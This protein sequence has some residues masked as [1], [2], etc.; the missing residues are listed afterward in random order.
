MPFI[1]V[2]YSTPLERD[3]RQEIAAFLT[4]S[5]GRVLRKNPEITAVRV[6]QVPA[7]NWFVAGKSLTEHRKATFFVAVHITR[8]TN[9]KEEKA[10]Y[11]REVFAGMEALL[12]PLHPESY[13]YVIDADG[14]AYG[15][16]GLTS[17]ARAGRAAPPPSR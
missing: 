5:T 4:E 9:L 8:G 6:E 11:H 3:L 2:K 17:D 7:S 14:D 13:I 10:A 1:D 12:G 16:G 15:F